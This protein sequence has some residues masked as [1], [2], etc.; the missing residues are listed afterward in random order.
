MDHNDFDFV[1]DLILPFYFFLKQIG[2][3]TDSP[4]ELMTKQPINPAYFIIPREFFV[5]EY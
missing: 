2:V 5:E 1:E 4:K 3:H